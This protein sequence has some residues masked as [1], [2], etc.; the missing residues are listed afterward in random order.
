MRL[1]YTIKI[2]VILSKQTLPR[3]WRNIK[4]NKSNDGQTKRKNI[5]KKCLLYVVSFAQ[6][7]SSFGI[8]RRPDFPQS[9][10]TTGTFQAI[11]MPVLVQSEQ[12]KPI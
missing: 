3:R 10:I 5:I 7:H 11:H 12:K 9:Y 6:D 2:L 8:T 1:P 4:H